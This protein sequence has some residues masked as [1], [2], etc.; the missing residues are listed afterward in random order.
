MTE[1]KREYAKINWSP[2]ATNVLDAGN[3]DLC[4]PD[5]TPIEF[6]RSSSGAF[7]LVTNSGRFE[8]EYNTQ[9]SYLMNQLEI[10][11]VYKKVHP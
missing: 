10:G 4:L 2:F 1:T 8:M 3:Y 9:M 11:G 6:H 7:I 5:G